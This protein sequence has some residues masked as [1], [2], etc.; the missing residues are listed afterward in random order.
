MTTIRTIIIVSASFEIAEYS[1][2]LRELVL[3]LI[4][5]INDSVNMYSNL[6]MYQ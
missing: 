3:D 4:R 1:G 6:I 5:S 2:K